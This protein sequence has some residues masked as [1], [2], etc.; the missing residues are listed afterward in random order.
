MSRIALERAIEEID[1]LIADPEAAEPEF[2]SWFEAHQIVFELMGYKKVI[3]HPRLTTNGTLL[4]TPDFLGQRIDGLWDII[5][6]KRADTEVLKDT[7][8]RKAF[9]SEMETYISQAHQDYSKYFNDRANRTEFLAAYGESVQES[10]DSLLIAGR[11]EGLDHQAVHRLISGRVPRIELRTYDTVRER[12][13]LHRARTFG[14]FEKLPGVTIHL[15]LALEQSA[16]PGERYILDIGASETHNRVT[17]RTDANG[18]FVFSAFDRAGLPH[19]TFVPRGPNTYDYNQLLYLC[20][21]VAGNDDR[22]M[23]RVEVDGTCRSEATLPGLDIGFPILPLPLVIGSDL[24]G[25]AHSSMF[26]T[27]QAVQ[28]HSSTF[29]ERVQLRAYLDQQFGTYFD[30]PD[31]RPTRLEFIGHKFVRSR[32]HPLF[33]TVDLDK[34]SPTDVVQENAAFRPIFRTAT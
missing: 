29:H 31:K 11:N 27:F 34:G 1:C 6:I 5:E 30:N 15:V 4:F 16:E 24:R 23:A 13:E 26:I 25:A 2:Q 8:R 3:P 21:E 18:N 28:G 19:Q 32:I 33:P 7:K 12:L 22:A 20:C 14:P 10:P 9:Y 17:L